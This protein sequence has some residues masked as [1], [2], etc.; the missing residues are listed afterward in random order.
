MDGHGRGQTWTRTD[1]DTDRQ[2]W[3][4]TDSEQ[5][6]R[7]KWTGTKTQNAKGQGYGQT[8]IRT[9]GDTD[10]QGHGLTETWTDRDTG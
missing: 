9:D 3:T 2:R 7:R 10:R 6:F 4:Q 1:M 5:S 8:G